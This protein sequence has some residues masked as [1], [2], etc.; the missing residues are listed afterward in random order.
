MSNRCHFLYLVG[1]LHK[2]GQE[3]Q[4]E[5]LLRSLDRERYRPA[6]AVWNYRARDLYLPMLRALDVPVY[7]VSNGRTRVSKVVALRRLVNTLA[8]AIVHSYA[9]YTNV[10]A[11]L[12]VMGTRAIAVGSVRSAFE[13][14]KTAAGPVLG[15]LSARW[16]RAQIFN[17]FAAAEEARRAKG[18]FRPRR[19]AVVAN[20]LDFDRFPK[21]GCAGDGRAEI[22][23]VGYLLPV[24]SW[25]RL[26]L[27]ALLLKQRRL[28]FNIRITGDGPLQQQL[29]Q[30]A[31]DLNVTEQVQ[32]VPHTDDVPG[33]LAR[34]SF[35]V[36]TSMSEGRPN[37]V[38][39]AM[40]AGRAV[41]ATSVGDVPRLIDEG[42][43]GFLVPVNDEAILAERMATLIAD[44]ALCRR[45]GSAGRMKAEREFSPDR[46]VSETLAAYR[47]A[48]WQDV[49]IGGHVSSL[50]P[51]ASSRLP[52]LG[53]R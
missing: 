3:R 50:N 8:P 11:S 1:S 27:A 36:H 12:G 44:R 52:P 29:E 34:A 48:G 4:L 40:A 7:P 41:V 2:G 31:R 25:D 46:L 24:K 32:F 33:L 49:S 16:P 9:F 5:L 14:A 20:G 21:L 6:V 38:M 42:V 26:L 15:R 53:G 22:V 37:S 43:T 28:D 39:E 23:G 10:A 18:M 17:S 47:D 45:M 51:Y 19:I 30:R 13:W 35:L